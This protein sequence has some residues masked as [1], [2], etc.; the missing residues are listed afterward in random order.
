MA[1]RSLR[2][3]L[4]GSLS[5]LT[6]TSCRLC[7]APLTEAQTYAVC[8]DCVQALEVATLR[9][10]CDVCGEPL[11]PDAMYATKFSTAAECLCAE[12]SAER[13]RFVRAT[14]FGSYDELRPAIHLMKFEGVPSLAVPLG[15]LL[16]TAI[17]AHRQGAAE[18]MA[19]VPVPL[20]RGKRAFN[21]STLLAESALQLIRSLDPAWKLT[22]RAGLLRR[23]RRTESQFLLSPAQRRTNL[24]GAFRAAADVSGLNVLLIDDVYTTGA[25]AAE[26]TRVLLAAGALSVRVATLARA[27]KHSAVYWQPMHAAVRDGPSQA[28]LYADSTAF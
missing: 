4:R 20:Y 6:P 10:P 17:L 9:N 24:R 16:A 18:E 11:A 28:N 23:T 12:C 21:Q 1:A 5:L 13:P 22:L 26:C 7:S 2:F 14:A 27:T 25:T 8:A 3:L 15:R 19:V